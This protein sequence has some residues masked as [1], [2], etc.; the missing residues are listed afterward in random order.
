M[1][2][3]KV[4]LEIQIKRGYQ[5]LGIQKDHEVNPSINLKT[6]RL[7]TLKKKDKK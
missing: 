4:C 3:V 2:I 1:K 5:D 7:I 6:V